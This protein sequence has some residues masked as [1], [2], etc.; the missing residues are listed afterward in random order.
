MNPI[1][2]RIVK[3]TLWGVAACA[4]LAC[5]FLARLVYVGDPEKSINLQFQGYVRLPRGSMLTILDYLT[6]SDRHLFVTDESN[7]SVYR[8]DLH[9]NALPQSTDVTVFASQPATHGVALDPSKQFAYV[10]R[11]E[12][13]SVDVFNPSTMRMIARIPV[14]DD[15]D[16]IFYDSFH[17]VIYVANGD[18][19]LATLIDPKSRAVTGTIPLGGKPEYFAFDSQTKLI[20][21]NLKDI[22]AVA[23]VD[24]TTRSV[25]QS[26]PLLGCIGPS[27]MALDET[28]RR[29]FIGC[30]GNA[31]LAVFD[32]NLHRVTALLS[33][34]GGPDSVAFDAELRRI[35]TTGKEGVLTVI[36]QDT[37][38]AYHVID[39]IKLHYGA[40]TLAVNPATHALYVAYA[41]L[42]VPSRVAVF[43]PRP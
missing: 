11:S 1:S 29:L 35:Y 19:N 4:V 25:A 13:N 12:A 24:V 7:G 42:L 37:P 31:M 43:T 36:R 39:S 23:A 18:A 33:I 2:K 21:Q 17:D 3:T 22:S 16:A 28:Q 41:S 34:G 20:Y 8:I 38:D 40:H 15:P 26:W 27:G 30:S 5:G 6:V 14:A 32:L 10:T 9:D